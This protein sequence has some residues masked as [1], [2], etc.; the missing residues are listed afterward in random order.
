V[1]AGGEVQLG[2]FSTYWSNC[3]P[4]LREPRAEFLERLCCVLDAERDWYL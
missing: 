1:R 3:Y 4:E 2:P